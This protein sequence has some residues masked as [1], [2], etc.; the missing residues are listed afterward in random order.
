MLRDGL[1]ARFLQRHDVREQL[2]ELEAAVVAARLTPTAA[3]G[4]LLALLDTAP[5]GAKR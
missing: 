2:P 5:A 3:A 1:E 4:R